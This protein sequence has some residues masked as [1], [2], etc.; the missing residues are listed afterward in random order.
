MPEEKMNTK[1]LI[2]IQ[3][4]L[5]I[6]KWKIPILA[7]ALSIMTAIFAISA[8]ADKDSDSDKKDQ[9]NAAKKTTINPWSIPMDEKI[10]LS[11][12][13]WKKRLSPEQYRILRKKG[14]EKAFSG[15]YNASKEHG[16]YR[17]AACGQ[18]LF[19]SSDKYDSGS[20]W[21][22]YTKPLEA[23]NVALEEDRS[24]FS[25][26]TEVL[27]ERC[28]SHLGHVFGDGPEPTGKRYCIN[29]GALTLEATDAKEN[30]SEEKSSD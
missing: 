28:G 10:K 8:L 30:K 18:P 13:Q 5:W 26:R 16:V 23:D 17:C 2:T 6:S 3:K 22:S 27:C 20:G 1:K 21:P 29:S 25:S 14:T 4:K 11:D 7:V 15:E 12:E 19:D 24:L 9:E